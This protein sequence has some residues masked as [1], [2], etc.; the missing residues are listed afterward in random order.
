MLRKKGFD[1]F[2]LADELFANVLGCS[3]LV[4]QLVITYVENLSCHYN[5]QQHLMK[6]LKV[7]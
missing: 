6:D 1:N 4:Y 3:K 2:K 7:L 5:H